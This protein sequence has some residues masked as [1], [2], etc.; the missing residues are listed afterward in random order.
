MANVLVVTPEGV[1]TELDFNASG[2]ARSPITGHF[3]NVRE[4]EGP[5]HHYLPARNVIAI[6]RRSSSD[7]SAE[8]ARV[9]R[10]REGAVVSAV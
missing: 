10:A 1:V 7:H 2:F 9:R 8:N 6:F 5:E 3:L 4:P